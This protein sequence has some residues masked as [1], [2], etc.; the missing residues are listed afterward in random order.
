MK[1]LFNQFIEQEFKM[2]R[3]LNE[4]VKVAKQLVKISNSNSNSNCKVT[5]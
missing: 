5:N 4:Q 3:Y 1:H 2:Y